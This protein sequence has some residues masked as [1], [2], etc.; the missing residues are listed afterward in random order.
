LSINFGSIAVNKKSADQTVTVKNDGTANLNIA[1][2]TL[3]GTNA[4]QFDLASDKCSKKTLAPNASCTVT[5]RFKPTATGAKTASLT[6]PSNDPD[7]N[8][9]NMSLSG[10]GTP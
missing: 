6:M 3:G 4:N 1:A 5:L 8:P 2:I 10:T 9:V 7:E